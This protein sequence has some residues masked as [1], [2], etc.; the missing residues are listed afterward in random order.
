VFVF[1]V[2]L[3][4]LKFTDRGIL[5][6]VGLGAGLK[7][8]LNR[9]ELQH[10][11]CLSAPGVLRPTTRMAHGRVILLVAETARALIERFGAHD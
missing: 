8:I 3:A 9:C 11:P 2:A 1:V 5:V 4:G 10:A 7:P 6:D